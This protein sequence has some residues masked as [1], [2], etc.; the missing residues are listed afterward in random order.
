MNPIE[1][2]WGHLKLPEV[3]MAYH[4]VAREPRRADGTHD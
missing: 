1:V 2:E 3:E 4:V